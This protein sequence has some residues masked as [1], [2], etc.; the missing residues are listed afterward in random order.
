[1]KQEVRK[2]LFHFSLSLPTRYYPTIIKV[3]LNSLVTGALLITLNII[4]GVLL[5]IRYCFLL[6]FN[7]LLQKYG[8]VVGTSLVRASVVRGPSVVR[9]FEIEWLNFSSH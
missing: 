1:M 4:V 9:G 8:T 2:L 6:I 7:G 3:T 5:Y